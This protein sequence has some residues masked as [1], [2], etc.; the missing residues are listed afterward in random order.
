L[1]KEDALYF[2]KHVRPKDKPFA[3]TVGKNTKAH[4][5]GCTICDEIVLDFV[6]QTIPPI[7]CILILTVPYPLHHTAFYPPKPVGQSYHPGGQWDPTIK[8]KKLYQNITYPRPPYNVTQAFEAL[9]N[10]FHISQKRY[11]QRWKSG[12]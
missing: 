12:E 3:L 5:N 1:A 7:T 10:I 8:Y 2:L 9:P 6:I 4:Q 11:D